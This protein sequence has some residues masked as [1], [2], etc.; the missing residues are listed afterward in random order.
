MTPEEIQELREW[1]ALKMEWVESTPFGMEWMGP[2]LDKLYGIDK[3]DWLPDR[4]ESG[5]IWMLVERMRELGYEVKLVTGLIGQKPH[6]LC[7]MWSSMDNEIEE[8]DPNPCLAILKAAKVT[9][10]AAAPE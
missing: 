8:F 6:Y 2:E 1:S 4:P 7:Q 9:E 5:Q 3:T 10:Q